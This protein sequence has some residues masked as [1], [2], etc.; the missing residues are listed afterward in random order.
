MKPK[1]VDSKKIFNVIKIQRN[2]QKDLINKKRHIYSNIFIFIFI[3]FIVFVF[4]IFYKEK[5]PIE[6]INKIK[7]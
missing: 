1:L 3:L 5:K 4:Y 2:I 6:K 7:K